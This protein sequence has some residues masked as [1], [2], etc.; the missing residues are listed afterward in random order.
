MK[1]DLEEQWLVRNGTDVADYLHARQPQAVIGLSEGGLHRLL[2]ELAH[3][4]PAADHRFCRCPLEDIVAEGRAEDFCLRAH[5][6]ILRELTGKDESSDVDSVT[7]FSRRYR[8]E[9]E[10]FGKDI[11]LILTGYEHLLSLPPEVRE[12]FVGG[13]VFT[14][15]DS[16]GPDLYRT[17]TMIF[18]QY[19]IWWCE[20]E[21]SPQ[22]SSVVYQRTTDWIVRE[23]PPEERKAI[24][25]ELPPEIRDGFLERTGLR[26]GPYL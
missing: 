26:M 18:S 8:G 7:T 22:Y 23:P 16:D 24:L 21:A 17:A 3:A 19:P 12:R 13:T 1:V 10:K 20:Y 11:V 9:R 4:S 6:R 2:E 14:F 5:R 15:C 25:P